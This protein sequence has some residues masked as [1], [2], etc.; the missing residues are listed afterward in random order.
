MYLQK[1]ITSLLKETGYEVFT[2]I[3]GEIAWEILM[4]KKP[5]LVLLDLILPR[6]DGFEVLEKMKSQRETKNIP[7]VVLTN[8]EEKFDIEKALSYG[9]RAYLVKTNYNPHEIV[10]KIKEILE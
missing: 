7:V 6:M 1:L 5:D 2:A 3:D 4:E 9:V 10:E 8:L